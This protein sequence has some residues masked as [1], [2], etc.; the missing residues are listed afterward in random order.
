MQV[1]KMCLDCGHYEI[2][3]RHLAICGPH[4]RKLEMGKNNGKKLQNK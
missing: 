2:E 3:K 4:V 1:R